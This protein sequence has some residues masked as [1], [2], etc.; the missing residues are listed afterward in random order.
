[1]YVGE[2]EGNLGESHRGTGDRTESGKVSNIYGAPS[3][4]DILGKYPERKEGVVCSRTSPYLS[5]LKHR[6]LFM[7]ME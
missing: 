3:F 6:V 2:K 4:M 1:M 7:E 5:R